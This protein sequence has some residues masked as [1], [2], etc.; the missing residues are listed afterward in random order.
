MC[1]ATIKFMRQELMKAHRQADEV[2]LISGIDG[3]PKDATEVVICYLALEAV[4]GSY[5]A[6]VACEAIKEW[7]RG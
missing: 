1:M 6:L 2:H 7:A 3:A 4:R 5:E